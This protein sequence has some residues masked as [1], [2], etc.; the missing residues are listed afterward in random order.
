MSRG[1]LLISVILWSVVALFVIY[2][3][4]FLMIESFKIAGTDRY[5]LQNY[6]DFFKDSII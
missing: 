2:P 3:L 4:S 6:I 5:G 1:N